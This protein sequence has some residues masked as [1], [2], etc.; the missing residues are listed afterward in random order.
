MRISGF[1]AVID[2]PP[3]YIEDVFSTWLYTGNGTSQT[4]TNNIDLSGKGGLVWGKRRQLAG[5]NV[6]CDTVRGAGNCLYTNSTSAGS[7]PGSNLTAFNS[8]GYSITDNWDSY[9]NN[10]SLFVSWTFRKQPKFFDI[11]TYTGNGTAGRTI[12][13]NLGSVPGCIIVKRT[14]TAS[15]WPVYHSGL[16]ATKAALLNLTDAASTWSVWNNTDPTSTVF[17]VNDAGEVNANGSTYVAY[18][19]ASNAGGFGATGT[20]NVITCG[21]FTMASGYSPTTVTLGY[22]PQWVMMKSSTSNSAGFN[23]GWSIMDNMRGLTNSYNMSTIPDPILQANTS[24]AEDN[25]Y[26][27]IDPTATGFI[28]SPAGSSD[29]NQTFIYIAIRRGPMKTPTDATKV[30]LP[31]TRTGNNTAGTLVTG[32]SW[33][34]DMLWISRRTG[35]GAGTGGFADVDRLRGAGYNNPNSA[36]L[37]PSS[38]DGEYTGASAQ[39]FNGASGDQ[40]KYIL[41]SGAG[42]NGLVNASGVTYIDYMFQRTPGFFDVVCYTGNG[43]SGATQTHNLSVTPELM[44]VKGRSASG[45]WYVYNVASGATKYMELDTTIAASAYSAIWNDTTPTSTQFTLG[46]YVQVNASGAT[47][48]AYLFA[49]LAGVSKVGSYTGNGSTQ[50]INCGFT[51]GARFLLIKRTDATGDWYVWDSARGMTSG[52]DP[53]LL[54]N[55]SAAEVTNTNYVDTDTT[56]FKVTAAAPAEINA[57][58]GTYIFLAIA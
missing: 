16:G 56:G 1:T 23:G 25:G 55:S 14:S 24:A 29:F 28:T 45:R 47:Y 7:P 12:S 36:L 11:V 2:S 53:Y 32:P 27:Y 18:L 13:H 40:Y 19:F 52:N 42:A 34:L 20:D 54:L 6:L 38:I 9:N 46:N 5:S 39:G 17:S 8:N 4:I 33:P 15:D 26:G 44:I 50:T 31:Q 51:G 35:G 22:E 49:T 21:S 58:G 57:S 41:P 3:N 10:G 43:T 37:L 30:F 48:V